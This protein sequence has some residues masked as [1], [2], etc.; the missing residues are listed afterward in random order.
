MGGGFLTT[1]GTKVHEGVLNES[2]FFIRGDLWDSWF[3]SSTQGA[4]DG[5][6]FLTTKGTKVHEG[7]SGGLWGGMNPALR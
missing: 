6:R 3:G 2:H 7:V 5:W 4:A 1:K